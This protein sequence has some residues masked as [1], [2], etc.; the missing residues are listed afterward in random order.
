MVLAGLLFTA[1]TI[2]ESRTFQFFGELVHRVETTEK[3]VALTFD[4]GPWGH[5]Y[6]LPLLRDYDAKAT[7]FVVGTQIERHMPIAEQ[8]V[9]EGH[10]LGNHSYHHPRMV[11]RTIG[12]VREQIEKTDQLIREA[13]YRGEIRFRPPFGKKFIALPYYLSKTNRV[14]IMWDVEPEFY[15]EI[16]RD[17]GKIVD[18]VVEHVRPGSIVLLHGS[19]KET[20]RAV[21]PMLR[22]LT[23]GGYRFVTIGELLSTE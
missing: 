15:P 8:I 5:E 4:D 17:S 6:I 16:A 7:F 22:E 11:L 20:S 9:S 2:H 10:E 12:W 19:W 1:W 23:A 13:G 21:E 3:V 18:H 14:T